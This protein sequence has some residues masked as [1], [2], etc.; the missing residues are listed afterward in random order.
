MGPLHSAAPAVTAHSAAQS[1]AQ[2]MTLQ[3]A[4]LQSATPLPAVLL[5]LAPL[6]LFVLPFVLLMPLLGAL[7]IAHCLLPLHHQLLWP[8]VLVVSSRRLL[9]GG[10]TGTAGRVAAGERWLLITNTR[11][12]G[13]RGPTPLHRTTMY[14]PFAVPSARRRLEAFAPATNCVPE[15]HVHCGPVPA[16][17]G[18]MTPQLVIVMQ[19]PGYLQYGRVWQLLPHCRAKVFGRFPLH[20]QA[21][22]VYGT[23]QGSPD[24]ICR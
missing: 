4:L 7:C 19:W 20:G 24:P 18:G 5:P 17:P 1:C 11:G 16:R 14:G 9:A 13:R 8:R 10:R 22:G 12:W 15:T 21:L 2:S 3:C 23:T 6:L